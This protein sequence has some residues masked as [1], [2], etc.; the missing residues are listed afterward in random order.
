MVSPES[1]GALDA[2]MHRPLML[3]IGGST[4]PASPLAAMISLTLQFDER[5]WARLATAAEHAGLSVDAFAN[6][7]I[8]QALEQFEPGDAFNQLADERWEGLLATGQSVPW[9]KAK[10]YLEAKARSESPPRPDAR[11]VPD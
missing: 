10:P 3:S 6:G 8:Q 5:L 7:A 1:A 9:D 2:A 11:H 4:L